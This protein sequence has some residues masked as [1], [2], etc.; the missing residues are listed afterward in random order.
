[1]IEWLIHSHCLKTA[2]KSTINFYFGKG[3]EI[4]REYSHLFDFHL[5]AYYVNSM[6]L[7]EN[8]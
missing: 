3:S 8:Y 7:Y 2:L 4:F 5:K 6:Q 1:M